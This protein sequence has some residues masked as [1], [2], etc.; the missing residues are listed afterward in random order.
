[1]STQRSLFQLA[2][3]AGYND[4]PDSLLAAGKIANQLALSAVQSNADFACV[5]FEIFYFEVADGQ[6]VPLDKCVSAVD[7]YSYRRSE[8]LYLPEIRT[9]VDPVSGLPAGPG[10]FVLGSYRLN[11]K[12]GKAS[13]MEAYYVP[14]ETWTNT[15]QG[16]LGVWVVGQRGRGRLGIAGSPSFAAIADSQFNTDNALTQARI[17]NLND[18]ARA[19]VPKVEAFILN[20]SGAA[21]WQP[22]H[23]YSSGDIRQPNYGHEDGCWYEVLI[24]GTSG[25]LE[26]EWPGEKGAVILEGTVLW[27]AVGFGAQHGQTMA[28]PVS[29]VD[30]YAYSASDACYYLPWWYYTGAVQAGTQ[31]PLGPS[32]KTPRMRRLRKSVV[33]RVV[34]SQ[35]DYWG[36]TALINTNDG[37]LGIMAIC[38]RAGPGAISP[39]ASSYVETDGSQFV[40]GQPPTDVNLKTLNQ[41]INFAR[42]RPEAF[43]SSGKVNGDAVP[44]PTS[45][46]D[47]YAYNRAELLYL[48]ILNDTGIATGLSFNHSLRDILFYTDAQLGIVTSRIDYFSEGNPATTTNG[49]FSI[50]TLAFRKAETLLSGV[51]II[52]I[53]GQATP[54]PPG[55]V[56]LIPNGAMEIWSHLLTAGVQMVGLPDLWSYDQNTQDGYPTQQPGLEGAYALGLNIGDAHGAPST[57][58][59]T[60]LSYPVAIF[61][62]G[63]YYFSILA[64]ANPAIS[65]G[66]RVR[67]HF[68]DANF[69]NDVYVTLINRIGLTTTKQKFESRLVMPLQGD[70]NMQTG[71]W[72][73]LTIVGGPLG[74]DPA[75][76]FLELGNYQPNISSTVIADSATLKNMG[77]TSNQPGAV[78]VRPTSNMLT[79][80]DA[81]T[82]ATVNVAA[83]TLR[84]AG[85]AD[86]SYSLGSISSLTFNTLYFIYCD[87]PT[88]RGGAQTYN[89]T[90][91]K[92]EALN[93]VGRIFL[94]SILTPAATLPNTTGNNDGG[95]G[96]QTGFS[97]STLPTQYAHLEAAH[98]TWPERSYD[99]ILATYALLTIQNGAPV[100]LDVFGYPNSPFGGSRVKLRIYSKFVHQNTAQGIIRYSKDGRAT[101]TDVRNSVADWDAS[102]TPDEIDV[103]GT[104]LGSLAV[105]AYGYQNSSGVSYLYLYEVPAMVSA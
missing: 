72:G 40:P 49:V 47:G 18:N 26:P 64:R 67:L 58:Y 98:A 73:S 14:G 61:P 95:A 52:P 1:M 97:F 103:S 25:A 76:V 105:E 57:Q 33:A 17:R 12:T 75:Y 60:C 45:P 48:T 31:I 96:A 9:T 78:A 22:N 8:L 20:G 29:P 89:A 27:I 39:P 51:S 69:D 77:E 4:L 10:G 62:G 83:F 93:G 70:L 86:V 35:V 101:W 44:L 68:R 41:N 90:V 55:D 82:S 2:N 63:T 71:K 91:T 79:A 42:L 88:L 30:G 38:V 53:V 24:A 56:N 7:G 43:L 100:G 104:P 50:L 23:A 59:M 46:S 11:Q 84:V 81:G 85:Q 87:D 92:E 94:G 13:I 16:T 102:V 36:G 34:S 32:V 99:N 80:T 37:V 5:G 28:Y 3:V 66:F 21:F 54:A 65:A 15:N 74:Y 19:S 6:E